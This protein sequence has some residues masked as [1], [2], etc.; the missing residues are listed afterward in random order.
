MEM[1]NQAVKAGW[2]DAAHIKKDARD[3]AN[4][5]FFKKQ[6]WDVNQN[7]ARSSLLRGGIKPCK[8]P[9]SISLLYH[10]PNSYGLQIRILTLI[11]SETKLH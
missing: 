7:V 11:A 1:L 3:N 2:R 8:R 9:D 10:L 5:G 6:D 4:E